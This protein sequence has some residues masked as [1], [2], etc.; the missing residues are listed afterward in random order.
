M[1][2]MMVPKSAIK[3]ILL[4]RGDCRGTDPA[5]LFRDEMTKEMKSIVPHIDCEKIESVL[6][7]GCGVCGI[8][9]RLAAILHFAHFWLFD[10]SEITQ[11]RQRYG[12]APQ[13]RFYTSF[14]AA[15]ELMLSNGVPEDRFEF[16]VAPGWIKRCERKFDLVLS[17]ISWCFHYPVE[18]YLDD[19][20]RVTRPGST[21][22]LDIRVAKPYRKALEKRFGKAREIEGVEKVHKATRLLMVKP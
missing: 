4:Q 16:C 9:A 20:D 15:R 13:D 10:K 22:I 3:Y 11:V 2:G 5:Q 12:V 7:I 14:D 1:G 17:L 19:V 8:D 18:K 6:D 21:I